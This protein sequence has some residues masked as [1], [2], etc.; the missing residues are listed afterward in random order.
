MKGYGIGLCAI[1]TIVH[2]DMRILECSA[3]G[4]VS[5]FMC[6]G[7]TERPLQARTGINVRR[8]KIECRVQRCETAHIVCP[9]AL[10][11][12]QVSILTPRC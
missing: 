10:V 2:D 7:I 8:Y 12:F 5:S 1:L 9:T 4:S 3:D 11:T 6:S